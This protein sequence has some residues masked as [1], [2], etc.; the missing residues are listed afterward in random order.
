M[1]IFFQSPKGFRPPVFRFKDNE[2]LQFFNESALTGDPEFFRKITQNICNPVELR[3]LPFPVPV[4]AVFKLLFFSLS[5]H[6][7]HL[8]DDNL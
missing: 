7:S 2:R 1:R 4:R 8:A 5:R 3:R 6:R